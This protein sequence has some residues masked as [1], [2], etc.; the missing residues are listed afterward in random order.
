MR[1]IYADNA[2]T[3]PVSKTA[4]DAMLPYLTDKF[5]NPSSLYSTGEQAKAALD[6]AREK[7]AG[8]LGCQTGEVFFTGGGTEAD[9]WAIRC[10]AELREKKGRH[11]ITSAVEHHAVI[12]LGEYMQK[13]GWD[14]TFLPV[15]NYGTVTPEALRE[16]MRDDTVL[17]SIIAA[18]NEIGTIN[19]VKELAAVAHERG[20]LFHTDAV[21]A[22]GHIPINVKDWDVDMLSLAGHKFGGPKGVGALYVRKGVNLPPLIWGGGQENGKRGGTENVAGICGMAA[23]L[24]AAV[25]NM[26]GNT[27]K[28]AAMRDRT[29]EGLLKVPYSS[30][31]GD[32]ANRLPGTASFIFECVEGETLILDLDKAGIAASTGSA[33]SSRSL[34]PSHVL[35]AIGLP[36]ETVHGSVRL[37]FNEQNSQEDVDYIL[38][39]LPGIVEKRRQMSPMWD[40]KKQK[41]AES[42]KF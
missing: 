35:M 27:K 21:Q 31:T 41:P 36:H 11:I 7:V 23:A 18:N 26:E 15:D 34:E 28:I 12:Y 40:A 39:T 2:G 10:G 30:L 38:E 29:I 22:V 4:L 14:V 9:N 6:Q 5:G 17:V 1:K 20:A 16:A 24:E 8:A 42:F 33:C 19:P 13:L 3:T 37:T 25:A 32:P